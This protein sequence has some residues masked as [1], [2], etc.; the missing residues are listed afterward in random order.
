MK[1]PQHNQEGFLI[2]SQKSDSSDIVVALLRILHRYGLND[3]RY[4]IFHRLLSEN[5]DWKSI[6]IAPLA[7]L[8][9]NCDCQSHYWGTRTVAQ[10]PRLIY[11]EDYGFPLLVRGKKEDTTRNS[12]YIFNQRKRMGFRGVYPGSSVLTPT[13]CHPFRGPCWLHGRWMA[14]MFALRWIPA[15]GS[16]RGRFMWEV[17]QMSLGGQKVLGKTRVPALDDCGYSRSRGWSDRCVI[18]IRLFGSFLYEVW[19]FL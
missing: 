7:C 19:L 6:F 17:S 1:F 2:L 16:S 14:L 15:L 10:G 4:F 18:E 11:L 13:I 8:V 5:L 12:N 9:D 3:V